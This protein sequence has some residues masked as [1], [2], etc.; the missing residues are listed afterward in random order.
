MEHI[1][2]NPR[3]IEALGGDPVYPDVSLRAH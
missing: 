2:A 1:A 3:D